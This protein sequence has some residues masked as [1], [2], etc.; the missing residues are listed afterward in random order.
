MN[1]KKRGTSYVAFIAIK[2]LTLYR[3]ISIDRITEHDT[4]S[5]PRNKIKGANNQ[6][7]KC[8]TS[9]QTITEH[10]INFIINV[11]CIIAY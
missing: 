11:L 8:G 5:K 6:K 9:L 1:N 2:L 4:L 3:R 10:R 7:F